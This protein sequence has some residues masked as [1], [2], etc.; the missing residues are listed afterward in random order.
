MTTS[1]P[2]GA[3]PSPAVA[4]TRID[5]AGGIGW[6]TVRYVLAK[7]LGI[8]ALAVATRHH[9]PAVFGV[10]AAVQLVGTWLSSLAEGGAAA[11][12]VTR[13]KGER[14]AELATARSVGL[15]LAMLQVAVMLLL[16]I[17][18]L[19]WLGIVQHDTVLQLLCLPAVLRAFDVVPEG[20]LRRD[21]Q[22]RQLAACD[23]V[24]DA[25]QATVT[26]SVSLLSPGVLGLATATVAGATARTIMLHAT[27]PV[28]FAL[29]WEPH[30]VADVRSLSAHA[31]LGG[32]LGTALNDSD[33][34]IIQRV[35]GQVV[36][37]QYSVGWSLAN[38]VNRLVSSATQGLALLLLA[39]AR[40]RGGSQAAVQEAWIRSSAA[41]A[42]PLMATAAAFAQPVVAI[43]YGPGWEAAA[44][45][46][47]LFSLFTAVRVFTSSTGSLLIAGERERLGSVIN[48]GTLLLYVPALLVA[49]SG[50]AMA[51]A[52]TVSVL[53]TLQAIGVNMY[54]S[55]YVGLT[56]GRYLRAVGGV[57]LVAAGGYGV[58]AAVLAVPQIASSRLAVVLVGG[59]L[60][61]LQYAAILA[62]TPDVRRALR[63]M[64]NRVRTRRVS[65]VEV[66]AA[67]SKSSKE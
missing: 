31:W 59:M 2:L 57:L 61:L 12:I 18:L 63:T 58:G 37:G 34:L 53:R 22:L 5:V 44:D 49:A 3:A 36:G 38:S 10:L 60:C 26:V 47:R 40:R 4:A 14:P 64:V 21:G 24:R 62:I 16:G 46:L 52:V 6:A 54:A 11:W 15:M 30:V 55:R 66:G 25:V 51:I 43:L 19:R 33:T 48:T 67:A 42:L 65:K 39:D 13:W 23:L 56:P 32:F 9:P 50:G 28:A 17:P 8:G 41:F 27:R 1:D 20:L 7:V 45:Y 29:A 35:F